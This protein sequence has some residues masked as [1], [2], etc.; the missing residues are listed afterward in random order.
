MT[1]KINGVW[2]GCGNGEWSEGGGCGTYG[3]GI[4]S[5]WPR[6]SAWLGMA[7]GGLDCVGCHGV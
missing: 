6:L 3:K 2:E 1:I 5:A 7:E 4:Y